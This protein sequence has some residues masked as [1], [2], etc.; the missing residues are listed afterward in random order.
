MT[1][2][3]AI[4]TAIALD[5]PRQ[6]FLTLISLAWPL[7]ISFTVGSLMRLVDTWMVGKLGK[8]EVAAIGPAGMYA[9]TFMGFFMG[10]VTANNIFGSQSHGRGDFRQ[11]S[12]FTWQAFYV[13]IMGGMALM[14][15]LWPG[16]QWLFSVSGHEPEVMEREVIYFRVLLLG[17]PANL[18]AV[19]LATFFDGTGR[20]W[21]S[22][23]TGAL[24][25]LVNVAANYALI[26]GNW[27]FPK[28]GIEGAALGTVL[29]LY[30]WLLML[31]AVYLTPFQ[32]RHYGTA[33]KPAILR[34]SLR[35]LVR[36]GAPMGLTWMLDMISWSI[37]VHF[38]I[39]RFGKIA[40]AA[41]T[42]CFTVLHFSF[43]PTVGMSVAV[44]V[45]TGR[46]LGQDRKADIHKL[47]VMALKVGVGYMGTL[48]LI[49][50]V[51][52]EQVIRMFGSD[53][54]IIRVG[55]PMLI[56]A[57]IFQGFDAVSIIVS[58]CLKGAGDTL[59]PAVM[60]I[61]LG[62]LLFLPSAYGLSLLL[63][64][65]GAWVGGT[66]F[67]CTLSFFYYMRYRSGKWMHKKLF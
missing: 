9:W 7:I 28:L 46:L 17:C 23:G 33:E 60:Q 19:A 53:P 26:Y 66:I 49:F 3:Q 18:A 15:L 45:L 37:F 5:T 62:L 64:P 55:G 4:S 38:L 11:C 61:S 29:S 24:S 41:N 58:A 14:A 12:H 6:R 50:G 22:A 1:Q 44:T 54:D 56:C 36:V 63:G 67:I 10:I 40:L 25:N 65:T 39:G 48:G 8:E 35:K 13:G 32:R 43:M 52:R 59:W 42:I 31:L 34:E 20:P 27:G 16:A 57:A 51:F 21:I 47:I 2:E 30:A